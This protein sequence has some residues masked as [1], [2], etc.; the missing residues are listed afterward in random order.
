MKTRQIMT[1]RRK[2]Q[3]EVEDGRHVVAKGLEIEVTSKL[4][5]DGFE[6]E[7][8]YRFWII[9]IDALELSRSLIAL[10]KNSG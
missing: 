2:D 8:V 4:K 7:N 9:D 3:N 1:A 5:S 10:L 6:Q